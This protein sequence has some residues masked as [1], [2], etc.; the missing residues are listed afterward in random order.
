MTNIKLLESAINLAHAR[1]DGVVIENKIYTIHDLVDILVKD[2]KRLE[3]LEKF[4]KL[5]VKKYVPLDS[6]S[7]KFWQS[8]EEWLELMSYDYYLFL[9]DDVCEYVVKDNQRLTLEE[10]KMIYELLKEVLEND[11]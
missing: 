11:K 6:L 1:K 2:L 9:C 8:K 4:Y 5:C 10:F 7:P 3:Q